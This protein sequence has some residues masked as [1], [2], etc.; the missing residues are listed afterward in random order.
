M[1]TLG[2]TI[3]FASLQLSGD[4]LVNPEMITFGSKTIS[5]AG[6]HF[7]HD[8]LTLTTTDAT[9]NKGNVGTIGFVYLRNLDL[10]NNALFGADG[11]NYW[12]SLLPGE[13]G[14]FRWNATNIHGK[15]SAATVPIEYFMVEN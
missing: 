1:A 2:L 8:K 13:C 14:L 7:I 10:T 9:L 12:L 4:Y 5:I 3:N 11:T 15:S 6:I